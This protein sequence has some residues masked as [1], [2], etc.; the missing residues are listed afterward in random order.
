MLSWLVNSQLYLAAGAALLTAG[1]LIRLGGDPQSAT[2]AFV[3]AATLTFYNVARSVPLLRASRTVSTRWNNTVLILMLATTAWLATRLSLP[4]WQILLMMSL[5]AVG[6]LIPFLPGTQSLRSFGL[7]KVPIVATV[8]AGTCVGLPASET[9]ADILQTI[10]LAAERFVFIA[11]ITLPFEIRD[12]RTDRDAGLTTLPHTIGHRRTSH[13][14][15][16]FIT[17]SLLL[18]V[19]SPLPRSATGSITLILAHALAAT[20]VALPRLKPTHRCD[21]GLDGTLILLAAGEC[22][23]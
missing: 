19:I 9:G 23:P 13:L 6:Y 11:A 2:V 14:A 18:A 1:S 8:W 20:L 21:Y 4:Q 12:R 7:L 5:L 22:L 15:L 17:L 16:G 3:F 10:S